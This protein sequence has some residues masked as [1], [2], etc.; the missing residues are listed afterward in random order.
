[1]V[2]SA[3]NSPGAVTIDGDV[4][5]GSA[6]ETF[7]EIGGL[8][9]GT[10]YDHLTVN[11]NLTFGGILKLSFINGYLGNAGDSFDLFDFTS[12]S[13]AFAQIAALNPLQNGLSWN[14][15]AASGVLSVV[16]ITPVPEPSELAMLLCGLGIAGLMARRQK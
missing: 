15:D 13:G 6:N 7:V 5:F 2:V 8:V 14:Y 16:S 10:D 11:G 3:G 9:Q 1:M 12:S 4:V